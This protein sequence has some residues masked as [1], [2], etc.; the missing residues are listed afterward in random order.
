MSIIVSAL[1]FSLGEKQTVMA[2]NDQKQERSH[3]HQV[4][5][6]FTWRAL[7]SL[8]RK[9]NPMLWSWIYW[10]VPSEQIR[11]EV[12]LD[13]SLSSS[14]NWFDI[15][16]SVPTKTPLSCKHRVL[17]IVNASICN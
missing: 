16:Y 5:C 7:Y 15:I 2:S 12:K 1:F 14:D 13:L 17:K 3:R 6:G 4:C 11:N 10:C 9:K 8:Q